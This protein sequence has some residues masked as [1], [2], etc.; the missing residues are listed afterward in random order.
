MIDQSILNSYL[1]QLNKEYLFRYINEEDIFCK[2]LGLNKVPNKVFKNP[3]RDDEHPTCSLYCGNDNRLRFTDW[4]GFTFNGKFKSWDCFD[5][6]QFILNSEGGVEIPFT[7][8]TGAITK[9][10]ITLNI[11]SN[12]TIILGNQQTKL[13][14][15]SFH[16]II[17]DIA[18]RFKIHKYSNVNTIE[19]LIL[20]KADKS[21]ITPKH[22]LTLLSF[23]SRNYNNNDYKYW[24]K[25]S[26]NIH[27]KED[28]LKMLYFNIYPV[29]YGYINNNLVYSYNI[30]DP[31]YAYLID[32]RN[33]NNTNIIQF[34]YPL[35][36]KGKRFMGNSNNSIVFGLKQLQPSLFGFITKSL[37]DCRVLRNYTLPINDYNNIPIQA[38]APPS[39]GVLINKDVYY[40]IRY[41]CDYWFTLFDYDYTGIRLSVIYY[42]EYRLSPI[43]LVFHKLPIDSVKRLIKEF[44][45]PLLKE[46]HN[47]SI[48]IKV[49]AK[50]F[51][52]NVE[53]LGK[54][55]MQK[56][57][58][59]IYYKLMDE[60]K[61]K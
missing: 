39:E 59:L 38:I 54:L 31:C 26:I 23:Q 58:N 21:I 51:T 11:N 43:Y 29:E 4:S 35:R 22:T 36:E 42:I 57:I 7:N 46:V 55:K 8:S 6:V 60:N 52:D 61:Y 10:R 44:G 14:T 18:K 33:N 40:Y 47:T 15:L 45:L 27:N 13:R 24:I 19:E 49:P 34:Y 1:P 5:L 17:E 30:K 20:T 25:Y 48:I 12:N 32:K 41:I 3:L 50:D 9:T 53:A 2:Y 28:L 56:L 37:K 16:L